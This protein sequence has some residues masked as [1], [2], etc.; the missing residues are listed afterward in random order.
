MDDQGVIYP[1]PAM[2]EPRQTAGDAANQPDW[3]EGLIVTVGPGPDGEIRGNTD[4]ALQ[5]AVDYLARLGGG[6][7]KILAG[8][9]RLRNT[10]HLASRVRLVG[11]GPETILIKEPSVTTAVLADSDWFDQEITLADASAFQP[12]DGV[13]LRSV[14]SDTGR[15]VVM[16][17]TLVARSGN[18][19]KLDRALR[20]NLW[21]RDGGTVSSLFSLLGG[22]EIEDV[23][24][25]NLTL[26]GN[27]SHNTELDGNHAGCIFLQDC[28]RVAIC[29]VQARNYHGDGISWQICHDVVIEGC[30]SE[31]HHGLGL[32]P[33]SGSQ[34]PIMRKN[35]LRQNHVG[36]F[37]CW[38]VRDGIAED[39]RIEGNRIGISVGIARNLISHNTEAGLVFRP[40]RGP[41]FVAHHNRVEANILRDNGGEA[42]A[43]I[44]L[45]GAT[46]A[47]EIIGNTIADSRGP[48][49]R[50]AIRL[51]SE[52]KEIVMADNTIEGFAQ[53]VEQQ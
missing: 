18:R 39:N 26:D 40:E 38:G 25:E 15:P 8:T 6:T 33:G 19:F 24:V 3:Q 48:A 31:G 46:H 10:V 53:E 4:K 49:R 47:I 45:Q 36:L 29:G 44:D 51:G 23:R 50:S 14:E 30:V 7:V 20:E 37:F 28:R 1:S 34:R 52:T 17:R 16:K 22:E 32:H 9:Y 11:E 35:L 12:G 13:C 5:A 21:C 27:R 2:S 42:D 43:A 41:D